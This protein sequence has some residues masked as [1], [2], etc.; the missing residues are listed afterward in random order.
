MP[1]SAYDTIS[2]VHFCAKFFGIYV[3]S[4]NPVT[5]AAEFKVVDLIFA[6][7]AVPFYL[8][9]AYVYCTFAINDIIIQSQIVAR[10]IPILMSIQFAIFTL[11]IVL[12]NVRRGDF[13]EMLTSLVEVD[14][15]FEYFGVKID[16]RQHGRTIKCSV[17]IIAVLI[18]FFGAF[19]VGSAIYGPQFDHRTEEHLFF[20]WSVSMSAIIMM[21]FKFAVVGVGRRF[22]KVNDIL[23]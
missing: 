2:S 8:M 15:S 16:Y 4:I 7:I 5:L 17:I 11:I 3:F 20:F 10:G 21:S 12:S 9:V 13:S 22:E 18:C 19:S 14:K 23:R 1:Q 6:A